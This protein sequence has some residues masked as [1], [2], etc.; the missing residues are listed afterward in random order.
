M[1]PTAYQLKYCE[2]CGSL[3]LRPADSAETYCQPCEQALFNWALPEETVR[4]LLR[5]PRP[6]QL[7]PLCG[8]LSPQVEPLCG[9]ERSGS[10]QAKSRASAR[11]LHSPNPAQNQNLKLPGR[12]Q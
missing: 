10:P 8:R 7:E 4:L 9:R 12:L 6:A 3:R 11:D 2:R 1:E 5:K